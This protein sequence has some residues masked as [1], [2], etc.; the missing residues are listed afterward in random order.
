ME[1]QLSKTSSGSS[2]GT[3]G[4]VHVH[5]KDAKTLLVIQA[6][7]NY[8]VALVNP[9]VQ[10][11]KFKKG[12]IKLRK[13]SKIPT[14][15]LDVYY[16]IHEHGSNTINFEYLIREIGEWDFITVRFIEYPDKEEANDDA[17]NDFQISNHTS[18]STVHYGDAD[19]D[20]D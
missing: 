2:T 12:H 20:D 1:K 18:E 19:E 15:M 17:T 14:N 16:T 13:G 8:P 4:I 7:F 5:L 11:N 6:N 3:E 10:A 9:N